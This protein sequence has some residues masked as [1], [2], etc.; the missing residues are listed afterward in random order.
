MAGV[1]TL[2]YSGLTCVCQN[3]ASSSSNPRESRLSK[4]CLCA[5]PPGPTHGNSVAHAVFGSDPARRSSL[6]PAELTRGMAIHSTEPQRS[7]SACS[8]ARSPAPL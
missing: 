1:L 7:T 3:F 4:N 6:P 8:P 2:P 5:C